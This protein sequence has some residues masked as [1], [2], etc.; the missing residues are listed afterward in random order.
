MSL[1]MPIPSLGTK[2]RNINKVTNKVIHHSKLGSL[3]RPALKGGRLGH[4]SPNFVTPI[5][6]SSLDIR[7]SHLLL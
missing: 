5:L 3:S 2:F 6:L 4:D 7:S 1:V